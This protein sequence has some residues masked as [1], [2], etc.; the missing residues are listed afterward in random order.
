MS[1]EKTKRT[2]AKR[3]FTWEKN[4]LLKSIDDQ[5][6]AAFCI[7]SFK[8]LKQ[9]WEDVQNTHEVYICSTNKEE[10][11][12][13][14]AWLE[15]LH[16]IYRDTEQEYYK[17]LELRS[18]PSTIGKTER[19]E[20]ND[21]LKSE[22]L[23][24]E[25]QFEYQIKLL[26]DLFNATNL[27]NIKVT[28]NNSYSDVKDAF[29]SVST[30]QEKYILSM[31]SEEGRNEFKRI[32]DSQAKFREVSHAYSRTLQ[33]VETKEMEL[34]RERPSGRNALKLE[35]MRLPSFDGDLK[36][37]TRFKADFTKFVLPEIEEDKAA[38]VLRSCLG[39]GPSHYVRN[40][41]DSIDAM[42]ERLD[43]KFGQPSTLAEV[44]MDEI[45]RFHVL[46]DFD[47][48][49]LGKF[50]DMIEGSYRDLVLVGMQNEIS[51]LSTVSLIE[52]KLPGTTR[53]KWAEEVSKDGSTVNKRNPFP[54]LIKFLIQ[55]RKAIEYM[56]SSLR[57][58]HRPIKHE[59]K[60][61]DRLLDKTLSPVSGCWIHNSS[62]HTIESC[63]VYLQ[64]SGADR[65]SFLKDN[66]ACWC[67]LAFGHRTT[68]CPNKVRCSSEGCGMF[69]NSTLRGAFVEGV[70][71]QTTT[72]HTPYSKVLFQIMNIPVY[73]QS[74]PVN[75]M[76]D[77]GSNCS[78]ISFEMA[79][80]LNLIGKPVKLAVQKVG[81]ELEDTE[82]IDSKLYN[83][84]LKDQKNKPVMFEVYGINRIS[85]DI[86]A[87]DIQGIS[88]LFSQSELCGL[89]EVKGTI[90]VLIGLDH[91]IYHP[92][93]VTQKGNLTI[94]SNCFG[95]CLCGSYYSE[96]KPTETMIS[97]VATNHF[98]G[99]SIAEFINAESLGRVYDT[100][101]K[102]SQK[103]INMT[104]KEE[105]ETRLIEEGLSFKDDHWEAC[106]PWQKDP[107]DLPNNRHTA[108]AIL[109]ST[110]RR[111][112]KNEETMTRYQSQIQDMLDRKV[113][114]I[115]PQ[116]ELLQYKG[117]LYYISHHEIWKPESESTPC[118]IVY[119]S[120]A[121][122]KGHV[123]NDYWVK[124]CSLINNLT[125]ILLRFRENYVGM[126][127][128]IQKMYHSIKLSALDQHT[129]RF[130]W[131]NFEILRE[132]DTYVMTSVCFGDRPA[133]TIAITALNKSVDMAPEE[134]AEA[135]CTVRDNTYVDDIIDSF[136]SP[137]VCKEIAQQIETMLRVGGF[138]IKSRTTTGN[139]EIIPDIE[140]ADV[141][142][143]D[144]SLVTGNH[145]NIVNLTEFLQND[146]KTPNQK[147]LGIYWDPQTDQFY[148]HIQFNLNRKRKGLRLGQP[149]QRE[150][151]INGMPMALTKRLILSWVNRLYDPL[152]LISPFI[153]RAKILMQKLWMNDEC[154]LSW[155]DPISEN[156][157]NE[158]N[159]F[160][161]DI[162]E[163]EKISFHRCVKPR[164]VSNDAP[165]LII[166]CD[167]SELAFGCS[168]YIR[169]RLLD[170]TYTSHLLISKTHVAPLRAITIVKLELNSARLGSRL[171]SFIDAEVR[172]KFGRSYF[173]VDSEIT[174][175]MIQ[176]DSHKL[177]SYYGVRI[178][179]IQERTSTS[180]WYWTCSANNVADWTTRGKSPSALHCNSQW[181]KG[182]SFLSLPESEWP[183]QQKFEVLTIPEVI[184]TVM[185]IVSDLKQDSL[186][187]RINI[188][189]FSSYVRLIR[190][191]ARILSMYI[192][193]P[194]LSFRNVIQHPTQMNLKQA[195]EYWIRD[196]QQSIS[197]FE[198]RFA[199]LGPVKSEDGIFRVGQRVQRWTDYNY[200][201]PGLVLLPGEHRLSYLYVLFIHRIGHNGVMATVSKVRLKFWVTNLNNMV[202]NLIKGCV[203]CRKHARALGEQ[204]MA[205]LPLER[206][207]PS[208][209]FYN[210]AVDYFGP[211]QIRGEVNRRS[212]GKGYGVL[213]TCL[214]TR[215][216]FADVA[217]N[218]STEGFLTVFRRFTCIRGYPAKMYSD[219]GKQFTAASKELRLTIKDLDWNRIRE[220][221]AEP[222]MEWHF[223]P[224]DA[225]WQ[226]GCVESLI[227][228][229]KKAIQ[230][231]IG[232]QVLKFS[233]LQT[234]LYEAANLVNERPIGKHPAD[235]EE[236]RYLCPNDILLGR[237]SSRVPGGPFK[238][239]SSR[240]RYEFLQKVVDVF[241]R[242]WT[243]HY[244]QSLIIRQKWHTEKRNLMIGDVVLIKDSNSI[245][246]KWKLGKVNKT[247][248]SA[249]GHVRRCVVVYKQQPPGMKLAANYTSIERPIQDLVVIIPKDE[250]VA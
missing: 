154:K 159:Q 83:L 11:A 172:I 3:K 20:S 116:N 21:K 80:K 145:R 218:Y 29:D 229:I 104:L 131:R 196:A 180:D 214:S 190:V 208:P 222:G 191:T 28:L 105:R 236:E 202:K 128:D 169:W 140:R 70:I 107:Y 94:V 119:N 247:I 212:M 35:R 230:L 39:Q 71:H 61:T 182:P 47:D 91:A 74:L 240:R 199:N 50:I 125:D 166:F 228:S 224:G 59:F 10:D 69:H 103:S 158:W 97:R 48:I 163:V 111:L 221:G 207:K 201:E 100:E 194:S 25:M 226:N 79:K 123:L 204:I 225:P 246:G 149:L 171:K 55:Q 87:I 27:Y 178:G 250:D 215:A 51:N 4:V 161:I 93:I 217:H 99:Q 157:Q 75:V 235:P 183:L 109:K 43:E 170:G 249:D 186:C 138:N 2:S 134:F 95:K 237:A 192:P 13:E 77:G 52:E 219:N 195:T 76:W 200:N 150:D 64:K 110:E 160:F 174:L 152:G 162:F 9:L 56:S 168:A 205:P 112:M 121:N 54:S 89:N 126:A 63:N 84:Q 179:E 120:S 53:R 73:E 248:S 8:R 227:K 124:G 234:V 7:E 233:E 19:P 210:V 147:V 78:L 135:K 243:H 188:D 142:K 33:D 238:E 37:Y 117:P 198:N 5:N 14:D 60:E 34:K 24:K 65:V 211:M 203:I 113:A 155:D 81:E 143:D 130:L 72:H 176:N 57:L 66:G 46:K 67:Y 137:T 216:V 1:Q 101:C 118:R 68:T 98:T 175:G 88:H 127:G 144:S 40:V 106:Y 185:T 245:R 23:L 239:V 231:A 58:P 129:H 92:Q 102:C 184:K 139:K 62:D 108:F 241:W 26:T 18:K 223:S 132:P 187:L 45:K 177:S 6:K 146:I 85:N 197:E 189:H 242:K 17:Y 209:P 86:E 42:W 38:Y 16:E 44:L 164:G 133:G 115:L 114:K 122:Y 148:F 31:P 22:C 96:D 206:L 213:F 82:I 49:A 90:D 167:S 36:G 181:Q 15:E 173:I 151:I 41:D 12:E 156:L 30:A 165:L 244:F 232:M 136:E 220:F 153:I 193:N 32:A 141:I